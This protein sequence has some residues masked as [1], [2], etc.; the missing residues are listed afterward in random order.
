MHRPAGWTRALCG[1]AEGMHTRAQHFQR[2]A[3]TSA[4]LDLPARSTESRIREPGRLGSQTDVSDTQTYM[5]GI[6]ND[7]KISADTSESIRSPKTSQKLHTY[8]VEVQN[9]AHRSQEGP[10]MAWMHWVHS[11][12][13][14]A[15]KL[16]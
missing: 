5:P 11:C 15:L 6:E 9:H 13:H 1:H 7:Q 10:D 8:L 2:L 3:N 16:T 12:M 14:R 4:N